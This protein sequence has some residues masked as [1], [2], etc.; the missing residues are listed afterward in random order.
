[1]KYYLL[2]III[3]ALLFAGCENSSNSPDGEVYLGGK[4]VNPN[5]DFLLLLKDDVPVDT[6]RLNE[7]GEFGE[8][9]EGL[10][11]GIYTFNHPPENQIMYLKPGDSVVLWLNTLQFDESINF[12]GRGAEESTFLLDMFLHNQ[13]NNDL[14]LSYYKIKPEKFAAKTDS[15]KKE[16]IAELD[17][18]K[19]KHHFSDEFL[20]IANASINYEYYDLRERYSFLIRKYFHQFEKEIPK[21]F[22][23]YRK[24]I[25]FNRENLQ[26]F[27]VY[28]N[29]IDDYLRTRSIEY[30][31]KNNISRRSCYDLNAFANVKRR[32]KMIDS[33][34]HTPGIKNEF[35]D[36][37]ASQSVIMSGTETRIDSILNLLEKLDYSNLK[38][39]QN[40]AQIHKNFLV[41]KSMKDKTLMN[42]D[43]EVVTYA[44]L[45]DKPL[46]TF[47]WSIYSP[48]HHKWQHK[49]IQDLRKKYPEVKFIGINIDQGEVKDWLT[50]VEKNNYNKNYEFQLAKRDM[51]EKTLRNY[52]SK[53]LFLN[54]DGVIVKGDAQ[55]NP[56][57]FEKDVV[58]FLNR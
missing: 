48:A 49:I 28:L 29:L 24:E 58:E 15:I 45:L 56:V 14:I 51:D 33:L 2:G 53:M 18:L 7:S 35:L 19:K 12:S 39:I 47:T 4:I 11:A 30:C 1:M 9:L 3:T 31:E 50:T 26:N 5:A 10:D 34:S 21:D 40:L 55:L 41:G 13:R 22:Y 52:I 38:D 25:D 16:R 57:T 36:R 6:L 27:Y 43:G 46:I 8:K 37:L 23:S 44:Q 42:T 32:M 54:K 17:K 20:D